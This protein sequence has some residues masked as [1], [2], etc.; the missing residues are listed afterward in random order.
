MHIRCHT[1]WSDYAYSAESPQHPWRVDSRDDAGHFRHCHRD[2]HLS[3][4]Q[5][6]TGS[7]KVSNIG[8]TIHNAESNV[9]RH[10]GIGAVVRLF[11][12]L[13]ELAGRSMNEHRRAI[14]IRFSHSASCRVPCCILGPGRHPLTSI[15]LIVDHRVGARGPVILRP[16]AEGSN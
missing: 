16:G 15:C 6:I 3:R 2:A 13:C 8:S 9:L 5:K 7:A 14:M 10:R 11:H 12:Q 1:C 4:L